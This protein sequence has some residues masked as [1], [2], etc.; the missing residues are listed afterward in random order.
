MLH[1]F[2]CKLLEIMHVFEYKLLEILHI[3]IYNMYKDSK[4]GVKLCLNERY[5]M[6]Y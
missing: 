4:N 6:S 1:V 5:M 2:E 3:I